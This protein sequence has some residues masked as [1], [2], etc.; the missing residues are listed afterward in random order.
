M[1]KFPKGLSKILSLLSAFTI[2]AYI[3][4]EYKFNQPVETYRYVLTFIFGFMFYFY[5]ELKD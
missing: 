3:T 2:G 4:Q 5:S 1:N